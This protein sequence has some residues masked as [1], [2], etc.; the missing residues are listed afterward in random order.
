MKMPLSVRSS[1][2]RSNQSSSNRAR[3]AASVIFIYRCLC[4]MK[5]LFQ[6]DY[7]EAAGSVA[8][9]YICGFVRGETPIRSC[10]LSCVV[11]KVEWLEIA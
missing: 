9:A 3:R 6:E 8:D 11:K 10:G 4:Q 2:G 7:G 5:C 1:S